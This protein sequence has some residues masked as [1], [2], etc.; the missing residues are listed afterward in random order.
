MFLFFAII[1]LWTNPRHIDIVISQK[2][3]YLLN[4]KW[5]DFF[6]QWEK[7]LMIQR[8]CYG[9]HHGKLSIWP[10][11]EEMDRIDILSSMIR[12]IL[13]NETKSTYHLVYDSL[14][15]KGD[16]YYVVKTLDVK[17]MHTHMCSMLTKCTWNVKIAQ[18]LVPQVCLWFSNS[19]QPS[20]VVG[21]KAMNERGE[22]C[23]RV[24]KEE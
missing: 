23:E 9:E 13:A 8:L 3:T 12:L 24:S 10:K 5:N 1:P 18:M 16:Y 2:I 21:W 17:I 11:E 19:T 4:S 15:R 7:P 20:M 14:L 6:L 22:A